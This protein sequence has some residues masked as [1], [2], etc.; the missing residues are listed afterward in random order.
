[1]AMSAT[2]PSRPAAKADDPSWLSISERGSVLGLRFLFFLSRAFGRTVTRAA[3]KPIVAYYLLVH[4]VARR[5]SRR[6]LSLFDA[7]VTLGMVY[8]HFLNFAEVV[9]DRVFLLQ[10]KLHHFDA[11]SRQGFDH[12]RRLIAEKRGA[13]LLGAHLGSVD[14]MRVLA[15]ANAVPINVLVYSGNARMINALLR[16]LSVEFAG[17]VV[18]I[19]PGHVESLLKVKQLID[20]GELVALLGDRVGVNERTTVVEFFGRPARLPAGPYLLAAVLGCPVYLTLGLYTSPRRYEFFCEPFIE[21][22]L[23]IPRESRDATIR[24]HAQRYAARLEHYCRLSP[25]NWFNFFDFWKM[26]P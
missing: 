5:A 22:P 1:V 25:M 10:G 8:R 16:S 14:A 26:D 11:I 9:L 17:R 19:E 3:L 18:E 23:V 24:L 2:G 12:M 21:A 13:L 6:Y 7:K 4:G 15:E 20:A